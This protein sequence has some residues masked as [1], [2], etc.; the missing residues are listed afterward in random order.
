MASRNGRIIPARGACSLAG[1]GQVFGDEVDR[2]EQ[3]IE[4]AKNRLMV[5]NSVARS[6]NDVQMLGDVGAFDFLVGKKL[7]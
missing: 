5:C 4:L 2:I 6:M 3:R 7:S 1:G